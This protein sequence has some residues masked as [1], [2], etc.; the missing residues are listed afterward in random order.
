MRCG[1]WIA[2]TV[3]V[4]SY[5]LATVM[6]ATLAV[7]GSVAALICWLWSGGSLWLVGALLLGAVVPYTLVVLM[8]TNR[9]LSATSL[10][11]NS[12]EAAALLDKW[13]RLHHVRSALGVAA[14]AVFIVL[15]VE[16]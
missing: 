9:R 15:L 14:A 3:W 12:E 13:G 7:V 8:P 1:S 4:P 10:N 6:Q 5:R 11:P 16:R 2:L